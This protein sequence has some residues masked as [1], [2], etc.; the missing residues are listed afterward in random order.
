M[1]KAA[2]ANEVARSLNTLASLIRTKL[3]EAEQAA[4]AA[5][6]PYWEEIGKLLLEAKEQFNTRADFEEWTKRQFSF[7]ARQAQIYIQLVGA[8]TIG[9]RRPIAKGNTLS[10][11]LRS[12]GKSP[13][14]H[15]GLEDR[16]SV[17]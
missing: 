1:P 17:V 2:E 14:G 13:R 9:G 12:V 4:E 10:D 6:R 3:Q 15:H 11:A 5:T 8:E 16:K 7:G